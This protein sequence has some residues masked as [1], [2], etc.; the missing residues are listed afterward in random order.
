MIIRNFNIVITSYNSNSLFLGG[1]LIKPIDGFNLLVTLRGHKD[2]HAGEEL[3]GI[4]EIE[5]A[6]SSYEPVLYIKESQYPNVILVELTMD[7][8]EA[9]AILNEAPTTVISK[10]V[11][12]DVV[13]KTRRDTI[14]ERVLLTAREKMSSENSFVV[15]CDLRGREYIESKEELIETVTDELL[16]N[17]DSI[18]D[19]TN[20]DWVVQI[21]V[22]GED[23]G[24]SILKPHQILKKI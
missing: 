16:N 19:E 7:P 5:L 13:V 24:I 9:V 21:E 1:G 4:E 12:I 6:L 23:T 3:V 17:V 10:V 2:A 18:V 11:P 20:P 8:E 14:L 15:R 22:V